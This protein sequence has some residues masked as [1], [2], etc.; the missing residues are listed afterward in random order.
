MKPKV[1]TYFYKPY[2]N[3]YRIYMIVDVTENTTSASAADDEPLFTD[4]EKARKRVYELN[5]WKWKEKTNS[6]SK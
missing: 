4:P 1:R 6:T 2:Y 3:M 5:G